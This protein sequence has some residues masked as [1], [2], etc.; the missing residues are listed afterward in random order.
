M[1]A[2]KAP[3]TMVCVE[4]DPLFPDEVREAGHK[5]LEDK[6]TEHEVKIYPGVPHG[7]YP[8]PC[9]HWALQTRAN[10]HQALLW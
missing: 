5:A 7:K 2:I 1:E 6:G 4:D 10:V 8:N 9:I 3:V